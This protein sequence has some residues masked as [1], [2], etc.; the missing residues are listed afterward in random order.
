M[1][2]VSFGKGSVQTI[3]PSPFG[4]DRLKTTISKYYYGP[5]S[6]SSP[7]G[8]TIQGRGVTP[9]VFLP[10]LKES[11]ISEASLSNAL[12]SEEEARDSGQTRLIC[13]KVEEAE[14][15]DKSFID[16]RTGEYDYA[17]ACAARFLQDMSASIPNLYGVELKDL[18]QP[19]V[20]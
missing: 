14:R 17:A 18:D 12:L 10:F 15:L 19:A 5:A 16:P 13:E 7:F 8:Y 4:R 20:E 3:A 9:D 11:E 6:L 1:G 2:R